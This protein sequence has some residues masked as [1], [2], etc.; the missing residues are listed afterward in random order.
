MS[1]VKQ[2]YQQ[3]IKSSINKVFKDRIAKVKAAKK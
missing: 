2:D 1:T 3:V